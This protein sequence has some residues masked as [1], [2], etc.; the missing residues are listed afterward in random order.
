MTRVHRSL[1]GGL[2]LAALIASLHAPAGADDGGCAQ[3]MQLQAQ[4]LSLEE[5]AATLGLSVDAVRGLCAA[6]HSVPAPASRVAGGAAGPAP[7]GAAGP[8]PMGAAGPAPLGAA[9]PAPLGAAGPAPM[10]A[11]GPAP[12]GA[13][14]GSGSTSTQIKR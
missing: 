7:M 12:M 1:R 14:G 6:P 5:I 9:G 11:A 2:V 10:G 13:A 3:A 8:A 4:G